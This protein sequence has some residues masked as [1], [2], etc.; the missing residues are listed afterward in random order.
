M[1]VAGYHV[2]CKAKLI[3]VQQGRH[4]YVIQNDAS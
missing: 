1:I 2:R 4:Y 3:I